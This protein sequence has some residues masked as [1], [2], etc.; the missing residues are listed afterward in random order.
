MTKEKANQKQQNDPEQQEGSKQFLWLM[1][2]LCF[3]LGLLFRQSFDPDYVLHSNDGPLGFIAS[4]ASRLPDAFTGFWQHLNWVGKPEASAVPNVSWLLLWLLSP[5]QYARFYGPISLLILG[6]SAFTYFKQLNF[7]NGV[8]SVAALAVTLN[9]N[10]FSN[11][12]W[13]LGSRALLLA[14]AFLALA[15]IQTRA[16]WP[17]WLRAVL[18]GACVGMVIMEGYDVGALF[19][20][21]IGGY[22]IFYTLFISEGKAATTKRPAWSGLGL[23]LIIVSSALVSSHALSTLI[24]TQIKGVTSIAEPAGSSEAE[25]KQELE[26]AQWNFATQ[27]SLPKV[28]S[29]RVLIPGLFGYRMDAVDGSSYWGAVGQTP[30]QPT[31]RFSGAGE[32][33]GVLVVLVV[34]WTL[35]QALAHSNTTFS[36]N[37]RRIL[38]FWALLCLVTLLLAFGRYAPFYQLVYP[39]PFFSNMRNPIKFMH[40]FHWGFLIL[41]AYGLNGLCKRYLNPEGSTTWNFGNAV[42]DW[43]DR[44]RGPDK[45]W[46]W[47]LCSIAGIS[48]LGTMLY[49]ASR[50]ELMRFLKSA[51]PPGT[52]EQLLQSIATFSFLEVAFFTLFFLLSAGLLVLLHAGFFRGL[53]VKWFLVIAGCLLAVDLG[54]ANMPWIVYWNVESKYASN[55]IID[56]LREKPYESRITLPILPLENQALQAFRVLGSVYDVEWKQHKFQYYGVQ[57]LDVIQLPRAPETYTKFHRYVKGDLLRFWELTNTGYLLTLSAV[58]PALNQQLGDIG[59]LFESVKEFSF[60][61]DENGAIDTLVST[62]GPFALVRYTE[63]L[64]R[65]RLYYHW[66]AQKDAEMALPLLTSADFNPQTKVLVSGDPTLASFDPDSE[67]ESSYSDVEITDYSAR[68]VSIQANAARTGILLL[69]DAYQRDWKVYVD[70]KPAPLLRCN[71]LMKGVKLSP[72]NHVVEFVYAPPSGSLWISLAGMLGALCLCGLALVGT[73]G[74]LNPA[75]DTKMDN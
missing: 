36:E 61:Q 6:A 3:L 70:G 34:F 28:E 57:S 72:G 39:L 60:V 23:L 53:R 27:W 19:S 42:K 51:H 24:G 58:V 21:A 44:S 46:A 45:A 68:K 33:A 5:L 7:R 32:Y 35:L 47:T 9:M 12:C 1:I 40:L 67:D 73:K 49:T 71:Y 65:S 74:F 30:G 48:L 56:H 63:A 54:R 4:A 75:R 66:T 52:E 41:F 26:L 43:W 8:A 64:P 14:F 37:E 50:G 55:E 15:C 13:G 18:A 17:A 22:W 59:P 38:Y 2:S 20:M 10:V 62:N 29:L 31:T 25:D 11:V 69:N 16:P